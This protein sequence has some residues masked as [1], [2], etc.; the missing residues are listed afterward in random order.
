MRQCKACPRAVSV[1]RRRRTFANPPGTDQGFGTCREKR[2][3]RDLGRFRPTSLERTDNFRTAWPTPLH[4]RVAACYGTDARLEFLENMDFFATFNF[5]GKRGKIEKK[6]VRSSTWTFSG[7][8][9]SLNLW[10]TEGV[11]RRFCVPKIGFR[12]LSFHKSETMRNRFV[13]NN[14]VCV[15]H[16]IIT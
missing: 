14:L 12:P 1:R 8:L 4:P 6:M 13:S 11:I 5:A 15:P 10:G 16:F 2:D 9:D 7:N 3:H